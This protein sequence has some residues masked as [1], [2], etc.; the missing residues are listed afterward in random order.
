MR[1][2]A[3]LGLV[4]LII[5]VLSSC[6]SR[7]SSRLFDTDGVVAKQKIEKI[8]D[9]VKKQDR[10]ELVLLFSKASINKAELFDE[11]IIDL[12]DYFRGDVISIDDW[13]GPY[14]ETSQE[15]GEVFQVTEATFDIETTECEYRVAIRFV[16]RDTKS[17]DNIGVESLYVIKMEDD[18]YP[19]SAYWGDGKFTPGINIGISN[20]E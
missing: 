11:S 13:G 7:G 18:A 3:L 15:N 6:Y 1:K 16:S 2:N 20:T 17:V 10:D 8:L 9:V 14:V 12:F 19:E 4:L 5:I